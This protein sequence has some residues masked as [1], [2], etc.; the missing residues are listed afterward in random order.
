MNQLTIK[1]VNPRNESIGDCVVRAF[2]AYFD[3]ELDYDSVKKEIIK[4]GKYDQSYERSY[5]FDKFA[6]EAGFVKIECRKR[7]GSKNEIKTFN[8]AIE[9]AKQFR[10]AI[11]CMSN[12]HAAYIDYKDGLIDTWD[13]RGKHMHYFYIHRDDAKLL[14]LEIKEDFN[15][16]YTNQVDHESTWIV[17]DGN[18]YSI[19][20][21]A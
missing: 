21:K 15:K 3:K 11:V 2:T 13:S 8:R 12:T 10:I 9:F 18:K 4:Y 16:N 5:V 7:Y 14:G 19:R 17:K 1:N 6:K 20:S